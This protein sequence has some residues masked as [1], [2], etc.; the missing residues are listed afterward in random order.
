[1]HIPIS[2]HFSF[3]RSARHVRARRSHKSRTMVLRS[4]S[5]S[6]EFMN[7]MLCGGECFLGGPAASI[8]EEVVDSPY[9]ESF[10]FFLVRAA[11]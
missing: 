3:K 11:K 4:L 7:K 6:D 2:T 8:K 10:D 1:M 9:Y 5:Y